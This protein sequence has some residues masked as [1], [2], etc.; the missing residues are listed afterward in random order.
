MFA[1]SCESQ[2]CKKKIDGGAKN[3][4]TVFALVSSRTQKK[5]PLFLHLRQF[6]F[7]TVAKHSGAKTK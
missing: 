3:G 1:H 7:Y 2:R 4:G 6:C 5:G